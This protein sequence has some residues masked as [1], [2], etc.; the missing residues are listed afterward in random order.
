MALIP[1]KCQNCNG[2]LQVDS[3]ASSYHCPFC[4][5]TYAM[6]QTINQTFQTTNIGSATIID[7]GSGK[8]DQEINGGEAFLNLKKYAA[9]QNTFRALTQS[10]AHKYRAW[11]GLARAITEDFTKAPS[12]Y[13]E[14]DEV[15]D[16][17]RSAQRFAPSEEKTQICLTSAPYLSKWRDYY[18]QLSNDRVQRLNDIESKTSELVAT[19]QEQIDKITASIAKKTKKL[20]TLDKVS[21]IVPIAGFALVCLLLFITAIQNDDKYIKNIFMSILTSGLGI[22]LPLKL[23]FFLVRKAVHIPTEMVINRSRKQI[24]KI[25]ADMQT[26]KD[27]LDSDLRTV[28][29]D[30]AWLDQ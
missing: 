27:L 13:N 8:I 9:A 24:G 1:I 5:T 20:Y 3:N 19:K 18:M 21:K 23:V 16:A 29:A 25:E 26:Q 22:F 11:W 14:F 10:Y 28:Y 12:G 15:E 6:E 30:T 2:T 4:D 7:D 17:V